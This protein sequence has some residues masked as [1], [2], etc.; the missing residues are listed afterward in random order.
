[1]ILPLETGIGP[2]SD[3]PSLLEE[4]FSVFSPLE[5]VDPVFGGR[6]ESVETIFFYF[7]FFGKFPFL[8][9]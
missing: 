6:A 1:M 7:F 3:D 4:S 8:P 9:I 2:P 5:E